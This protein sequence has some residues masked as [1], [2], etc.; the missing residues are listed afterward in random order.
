MFLRAYEPLEKHLEVGKALVIFGPRRTG[1]TTILQQFLKKTHKRYKLD[2]GDNIRVRDI[3][4]SQ[5]FSRIISYLEGYDIYAIDEAQNIPS[6]GMALKI[7][8]DQCP[9]MQVVVTGSS[10]FELAGQIGE[11]LTGRKKTF[12]LYPM[13]QLELLQSYNRF[14]LTEGLS[15]FLVFGSYPE[16]L[17][18]STYNKKK[19]LLY[20]LTQS[21]LLKDILAFDKIKHSRTLLDLLMLLAYQIGNEVSLNELAT[22]LNI[23]V[24]TVQ[25]Y[26]DL[27]EKTFVIIRFNGFSRNLRDEV[28]NKAK[29]YFIDTGIRNALINQF[30]PLDMRNDQGALWENF[31]QV[32]RIK[33]R[34]YK[35]MYAHSYFW[36]TYQQQEIDLIEEYEGK[37]HAFEFKWSSKKQVR[38]PKTWSTAYPDADYKVI[39]P[40]NYQSIIL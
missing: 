20:E 14:E 30:N 38:P 11:P 5:D 23:D 36:R 39:T 27:L 8:V 28:T 6:I 25:R 19:E 26:L 32:E 2:S 29:Y 21:Y 9:N 22:K 3:L 31:M 1:K 24:K 40:E 15:D 13:S 18:A 17:T 34:T 4:G 33:Y 12:I 37:L 35:G 10:S 16:V 7:I